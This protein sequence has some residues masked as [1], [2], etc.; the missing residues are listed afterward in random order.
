MAGVWRL[1]CYWRTNGNRHL[2]YQAIFYLYFFPNVGIANCFLPDT[3]VLDECE[4]LYQKFPEKS[5]EVPLKKSK[6]KD[7]G[8]RLKIVD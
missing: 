8:D 5:I 1:Y 3:C 6:T 7:L 2:R 4:K